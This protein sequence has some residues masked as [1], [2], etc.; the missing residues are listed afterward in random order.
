MNIILT[1]LTAPGSPR[2][3]DD[4]IQHQSKVVAQ[5]TVGDANCGISR[6]KKFSRCDYHYF[7]MWSRGILELSA[8][9]NAMMDPN[10]C[11]KIVQ[12]IPTKR[13]IDNDD[14]FLMHESIPAAPS[15][16]PPIFVSFTSVL[17]PK[18]LPSERKNCKQFAGGRG[19]GYGRKWLMHLEATT[20]CQSYW[21]FCF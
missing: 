11:N 20:V 3:A 10:V 16:F 9:F 6:N 8:N 15:I 19:W 7:L 14:D 5:Q 1:R 17:V 21:T 12:S 2:M 13:Q 18:N 4:M